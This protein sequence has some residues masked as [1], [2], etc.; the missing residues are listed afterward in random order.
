MSNLKYSFI[1]FV[2][3]F[4]L[5]AVVPYEELVG[6]YSVH[7]ESANFTATITLKETGDIALRTQ[8]GCNAEGTA[9]TAYQN[10]ILIISYTCDDDS[11]EF[12]SG[13]MVSLSEVKNLNQFS[14]TALVSAKEFSNGLPGIWQ[15]VQ[16][17]FTKNIH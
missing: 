8:G 11:D 10:K 2:I 1:L 17:A 14:T 5:Y 13:W 16:M 9:E 7:V 3:S 12:L 6:Q 4:S 15:Q